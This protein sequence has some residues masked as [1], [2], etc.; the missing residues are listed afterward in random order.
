MAT[1]PG[2]L[3]AAYELLTEKTYILGR[4]M[5]SAMAGCESSKG[6]ILP[7]GF[8]LPE[9]TACHASVKIEDGC[10]II[11]DLGSTNGTF[12]DNGKK[13]LQGTVR[14]DLPVTIQLG[15]DLVS[16]TITGPGKIYQRDSKP[17][18][19]NLESLGDGE[20]IQIGRE[21]TCDLVL[22][23]PSISRRHCCIS[24]RGGTFTVQDLQSLNGTF[25]NGRPL[26][27]PCTLNPGDVLQAGP[28]TIRWTGQSSLLAESTSGLAVNA[29][30]LTCIAGGRRRK[31]V[32]L[33]DVNFNIHPGEF[34][35]I[36]GPSGS[37]KS[38]LLRRLHGSLNHPEQ[39][40][41]LRLGNFSIP[42]ERGAVSSLLGYIPQE[43]TLHPLLTLKQTLSY[44][45]RLH[46]P[47]RLTRAEQEKHI[48]AVLSTLNLQNHT[49]SRI[50]TLSG[51]ERK[52]AELAA[53]LLAKPSLLL[54]DEITSGLDAATEHNL[55]RSFRNLAD[56]GM[57]I[58]CITHHMEN[59][60]LCDK[61]LVIASD[62]EFQAA[63]KQVF[64]G[65]PDSCLAH[66][67][68]SS[69]VQIFD[70]LPILASRPKQPIE[71]QNED[72]EGN[73]V[74][75]S[76]VVGELNQPRSIGVVRQFSAL[77]S[78]QLALRRADRRA[79][80]IWLGQPVLLWIILVIAFRGMDMQWFG[81]GSPSWKTA[82]LLATAA[83]WFSTNNAARDISS[84]QTFLSRERLAGIKL[85][86]YLTAKYLPQLV[87][88]WLQMLLLLFLVWISPG[89]IRNGNFNEA[90]AGIVPFGEAAIIFLAATAAGAACGLA[91]SAAVKSERQATVLLPYVLLPQIIL[92]G[93]LVPTVLTGTLS[94][95]LRTIAGAIMPLN[96]VYRG[97]RRGEA[98]LPAVYPL[99]GNNSGDPQVYGA[100]HEHGMFWYHDAASVTNPAF[101]IEPSVL[102][103]FA[104][105]FLLLSLLL[106][107]K[108]R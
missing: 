38:T 98:A 27:E 9:I 62:P 11:T 97:L 2:K 35:A 10:V 8:S 89:N 20:T 34:V 50:K 52:R 91:L 65:S 29:R 23:H 22:D 31:T 92:G 4:D 7:V 80:L 6:T 104:V 63:G 14:L 77:L 25:I 96:W 44:A 108:N 45:L 21:E 99:P 19:L 49:D 46:F 57:T 106:L 67:A 87:L 66:F 68:V 12:T 16:L 32:V 94:G 90:F 47:D 101:W 86:P 76:D 55:M 84:E 43:E 56:S 36:I 82:F 28:F 15:R 18:E 103:L 83:I 95:C 41:I 5:R 39:T 85:T 70:K 33:R 78:R 37:G 40:G 69:F 105:L 51:G 54:L 1:A 3:S 73:S 81:P 93:A 60:R 30:D 58:I 24:R 13:Q 61:V 102:I 71:K 107:K 59:V 17:L 26:Q 74:N 72:T 88:G 42:E 53:E 48:K 75:Q 64:F 79:L 100:I